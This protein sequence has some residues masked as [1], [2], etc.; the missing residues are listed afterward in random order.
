[1]LIKIGLDCLGN[2]LYNTCPYYCLLPVNLKKEVA[3]KELVEQLF[4]ARVS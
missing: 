4:I 2:E 3:I 1:M